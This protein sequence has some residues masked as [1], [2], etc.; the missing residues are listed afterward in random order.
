MNWQVLG[1]RG[2]A[3]YEEGLFNQVTDFGRLALAIFGFAAY[4]TDI[5]SQ[6]LSKEA[7]RWSAERIRSRG[8]RSLS[9]ELL[10]L[11]FRSA[12][13]LYSAGSH[14]FQQTHPAVS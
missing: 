5:R 13:N 6:R 8:Q 2:T 9:S 3:T 4:Y 1:L 11:S 14:E 10:T 12:I 7:L